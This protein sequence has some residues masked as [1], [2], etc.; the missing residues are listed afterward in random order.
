M[1]TEKLLKVLLFAVNEKANQ[2]VALMNQHPKGS[3]KRHFYHGQYMAFNE[4]Y[5]LMSNQK[6]HA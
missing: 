3:D 1:T 4:L 5:S 6:T 2:A